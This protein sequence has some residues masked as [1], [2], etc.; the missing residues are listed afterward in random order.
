MKGPGEKQLSGAEKT[1]LRQKRTL[2]GL[3]RLCADRRN[4]IMA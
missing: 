1:H 4:Y 2:R 3:N